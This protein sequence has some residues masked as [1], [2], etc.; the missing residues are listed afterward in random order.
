MTLVI[1]N[2]SGLE[3]SNTYIG[4]ED[5]RALA[6][7]RGISLSTSDEVLSAQLVN[8]ADRIGTYEP[9]F[10]GRRVNG[11]QGLSYP[12]ENSY[13]FGASLP[14]DAIPK[15]LKLA[16]ITIANILEEGG[17]IWATSYAGITRETVGPITTEY[18]DS[19]AESVG[20]PELPQVDAILL[21]LLTPLSINFR[22][23][24]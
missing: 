16:Q 2:G 4:L 18:A 19:A 10:S 7:T 6:L 14:N 17:D 8:A 1:E 23:G 9:R 21:P 12:R 15:E 11:E 13:R 5:A 20:N 24:R 3:D 22:V